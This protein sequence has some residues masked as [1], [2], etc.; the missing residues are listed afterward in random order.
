MGASSYKSLGYSSISP[1]LS[2][3]QSRY[4][5]CKADRPSRWRVCCVVFF[6][7]AV[8]AV[9]GS[10]VWGASIVW[11]GSVATDFGDG[12]NCGIFE[13]V[14]DT[15]TDIGVFSAIPVTANPALT[16]SRSINEL[17]STT[18]SGG[19]TL[20]GA[21]TVSLG[22]GGINTPGQTSGTN[23]ISA[24]LTPATSSNRFVG[25]GGQL[26]ITGCVAAA[27]AFTVTLNDACNAGTLSLEGTA[28]NLNV[29]LTMNNGTADPAKASSSIVHPLHG[30][31]TIAG[32]T[33]VEITGGGGDQISNTRSVY[34]QN[35]TFNV[36]GQ[37][38][39]IASIQ[40]GNL[41]VNPIGPPFIR[42]G[43]GIHA[44]DLRDARQAKELKYATQSGSPTGRLFRGPER[45]LQIRRKADPSKLVISLQTQT[46]GYRTLNPDV[47]LSEAVRI[48]CKIHSSA[49]E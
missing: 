19:W 21:F 45:F 29:T 12:A 17:Q 1:G 35:G 34:L 25:T 30:N 5:F 33:T 10:K 41:I 44:E 6:L 24:N 39:T 13:P 11:S 46:K 28:N 8:W 20:G 16:M 38:E 3:R 27:T 31:V 42:G 9:G 18:P 43:A 48:W 49:L 40:I 32:H 23:T 15:T 14:N 7:L 26:S 4:S 36:N 37:T 22:R 47:F 2:M